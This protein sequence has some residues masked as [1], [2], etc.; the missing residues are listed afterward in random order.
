MLSRK[1]K[2]W[3]KSEKLG[4]CDYIYKRGPYVGAKVVSG[5]VNRTVMWDNKRFTRT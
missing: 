1:N 4:C 3:E 5:S 2:K